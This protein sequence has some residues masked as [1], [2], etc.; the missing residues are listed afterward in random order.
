VRYIASLPN[1]HVEGL[2]THFATADEADPTDA[3]RQFQRFRAVLD[4]LANI[5]Y[6]IAVP[7]ICNSAGLVTVPEAHMAAVRPGLLIYGMAPSPASMPPFPLQRAISLKT[8]II[9]VR[10]LKPGASISYGRT[11]VATKPMR[12]AL[13]PLGYGDGYP[14]QASNRGAVLI[15]GQR[16]PIRGRICMDQMIVDVTDIPDV[17]VGE[18][19]V[20]IGQ[21]GD[22]EI[23]AEEVAAW[24][25]SINYEVVTG[26]LPQVVRVYKLNGYY[27]APHEGLEQWASYLRAL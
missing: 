14:R 16:A 27:P 25:D 21:Q 1:L 13:I 26:L 19:A 15:H 4:E 2:F 18:E 10:D 5:G 23:T 3:R 24:S 17:H 22:G 7:H 9:H 6:P 20:A 12:V 11:F 8:T